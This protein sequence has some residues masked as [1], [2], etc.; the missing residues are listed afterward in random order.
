VSKKPKTLKG[1]TEEKIIH[2]PLISKRIALIIIGIISVSLAVLTAWQLI[3][4]RGWVGGILWGLLYGVLV[5]AMFFGNIL[6][7]RFLRK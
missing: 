3:P 2:Q 6:I 5:W 4:S 7:K 1:P